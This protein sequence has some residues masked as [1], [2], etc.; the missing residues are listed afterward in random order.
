MKKSKGIKN[1]ERRKR[2]GKRRIFFLIFPNKDYSTFQLIKRKFLCLISF[3]SIVKM[4]ML[5]VVLKKVINLRLS[6]LL[7]CAVVTDALTVKRLWLQEKKQELEKLFE[8]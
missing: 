4:F 6:V 3:K 1:K 8:Y 7:S 5:R 2:K